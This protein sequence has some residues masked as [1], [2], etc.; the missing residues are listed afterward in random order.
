[1]P[2]TATGK[3]SARTDQLKHLAHHEEIRPLLRVLWSDK[4]LRSFGHSLLGLIS[5]VT[6]RLHADFMV[7]GAKSGRI[8]ANRPNLQQLP[9]DVRKAVVAPAGKVLVCADYSQ[10][11]L[12]VLAELAGDSALRRV[13]ATGGDVHRSAAARIAGVPLERVTPEQR[14]AAKAIVF[15]TIYGSGARGLR[16]SAWANF[17]VELSIEEAGAAKEALFRAYPGIRDYR[18]DQ[19]DR[20]QQ[21]GMLWSVA[22]RPLRARWEKGGQIRYTVAV[23]YV[24]QASAADTLLVA[25]AN[26]DRALPGSMILTVHDELVCEV[27]EARA[28]EA[29]AFLPASMGAAFSELFPGAPLNGLVAAKIAHCWADAK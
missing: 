2:R 3:L 20:A 8:T 22:G 14:R 15:G 19:A 11:E 7:C 9:P 26:V 23:N 21:E 13:F 6:G 25:M 17:D 29:V 10:I 28:E 1:M 4:R 5:P 16:A 12:R 27:D 24:V 18:R